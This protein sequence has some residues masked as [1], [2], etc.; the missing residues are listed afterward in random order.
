MLL[1][2]VPG[3]LHLPV[4][5]HAGVAVLL[6][7]HALEA[8]LL[9]VRPRVHA[10]QLALKVGRQVLSSHD[11]SKR[12]KPKKLSTLQCHPL[13]LWLQRAY[14]NLGIQSGRD[15]KPNLDPPALVK[16]LSTRRIHPCNAFCNA[17][18]RVATQI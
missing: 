10:V 2:A 6:G 8:V 3:P 12:T 17:L 16:K 11:V 18:K 9:L 1:E 14:E 13:P 5:Q 15:R 7:H 4:A